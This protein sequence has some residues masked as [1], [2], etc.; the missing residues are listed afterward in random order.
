MYSTSKMVGVLLTVRT[1][2]PIICRGLI[3]V[4]LTDFHSKCYK[5]D[6]NENGIT[7]RD[8]IMTLNDNFTI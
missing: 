6:P 3:I 8:R 2:H 5:K 7:D 1:Y 4:C